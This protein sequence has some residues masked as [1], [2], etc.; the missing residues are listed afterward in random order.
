VLGRAELRV[1][2]LTLGKVELRV[3]DDDPTVAGQG[4][5]PTE[6]RTTSERL[7]W[8]FLAVFVEHGSHK[9]ACSANMSLVV[10]SKLTTHGFHRGSSYPMKNFLSSIAALSGSPPS[11]T[12]D[13]PEG[14]I[15]PNSTTFAFLSV[16]LIAS[17]LIL[18]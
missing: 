18:R 11:T 16:L 15:P 6:Q 7:R 1:A 9:R 17:G 13:N 3:T 5:H 8:T 4:S 2:M 14:P 10:M 12:L